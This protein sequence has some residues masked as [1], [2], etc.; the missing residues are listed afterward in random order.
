MKAIRPIKFRGKDNHGKW[1]EGCYVKFDGL[2]GAIYYPIYHRVQGDEFKVVRTDWCYVDEE[3]VGQFTGLRD[4]NGRNIY[5]GDILKV[6][7]EK[8]KIEVR[9][10][11][12]VFAFLWDGNLDDEFP[13]GSPTYE[14]A[15]VVGNIHDNP[16]MLKR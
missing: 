5:E 6:G 1:R 3:T 13:T 12:G 7:D 10:V 11:R 4:K 8:Q 15:E 14:W 2:Q 16:K 9:F